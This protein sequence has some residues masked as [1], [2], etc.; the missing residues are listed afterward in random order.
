[1]RSEQFQRFLN[2]I[3]SSTKKQR[4]ILDEAL[5]QQDSS[6]ILEQVI[7]R[8]FNEHPV[9]PLCKSENIHQ[10]DIR[11]QRQRTTVRIATTHLMRSAKGLLPDFSILKDGIGILKA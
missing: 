8:R 9:C 4:I 7:E 2:D 3:P 1:M 11:N 6:N 10:W 5:A